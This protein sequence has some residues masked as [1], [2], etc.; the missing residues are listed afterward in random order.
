DTTTTTT[1]PIPPELGV[2][3]SQDT[4][5]NKIIATEDEESFQKALAYIAKIL[6]ERNGREVLAE[7]FKRWARGCCC[8]GQG[9]GLMRRVNYKGIRMSSCRLV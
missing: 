9:E 4:I 1:Y 8:Q 7:E 3:S 5:P 6:K 2:D